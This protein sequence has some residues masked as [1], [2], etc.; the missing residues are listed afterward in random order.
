MKGKCPFLVILACLSFISCAS[1]KAMS[2]EDP[3]HFK[4]EGIVNG[5]IAF[6]GIRPFD[7]TIIEAGL[8]GTSNRWGDIASVD[9]WPAGGFGVSFIGCRIKI[10]A[11]E[12][13][14]GMLGYNPRPEVYPMKEEKEPPPGQERQPRE[15]G[16]SLLFVEEVLNQSGSNQ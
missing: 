11:W 7:G 13:G 14:I 4:S 1:L 15:K 8:L 10:L 12:A 16:K 9:G 6:N 3:P 2:G 5:Y